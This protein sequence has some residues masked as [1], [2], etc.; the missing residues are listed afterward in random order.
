MQELTE[1]TCLSKRYTLLRRVASGG[2]ADVWLASDSR[3]DALLALKFLQGRFAGDRLRREAF[4][5]E[6]Q[7][8]SRLMHAH[9]VRVF[10]YHD[11]ED[12]PYFGQQY[13]DGPSISTLQGQALERVLGPVGLIA[14]ALRYA[15]GKGIVH[16]DITGANIVLD[17]RGAPYLLDFGVARLEGADEGRGGG[18]P[19]AQSPQQRA[20]ERAHPADDIYAFGVL[21]NELVSGAPPNDGVAADYDSHGGKLPS[22]LRDLL[23]RMLA[24]ERDARPA[25]E[26]VATALREAGFEPGLAQ[27]PNMP[28]A[29]AEMP[30]EIEVRAV[31]PRPGGQ[32]PAA[33]SS[34][35]RGIPARVVAVG[36][37][38]LLVA[39]LAVLFVLP[40]STESP[41]GESV[42]LQV[43]EPDA[44]ADKVI[45]GDAAVE[46]SVEDSEDVT[47]SE[48]LSPTDGSTTAAIKAATDEAL[49]DLLSQL[50]RLRFR[51]IERWGGQSYL[52]ALDRYAAGDQAYIARNYQAAGDHYRAT[53]TML[54]PFFD[55]IPL[56]F[57]ETM[58]AARDA[59]AAQDHREAIRL[60]DLAVAI[61]PGNADAESGL[62]RARNLDKVLQLMDRG[63]QF[64]T[65]LEYD[66]AQQAFS[67]VLQLDPAWQ[68]AEDAL[69]RISSVLEQLAF[70]SRMTE[71]FNALATDNFDS[72]RVAFEAAKAMRPGSPQPV[73]GLQQVD[74]EVRLQRIQTLEATAARQE[75][76]EQWEAAVDSY[77]EVLSV[78]GDLQFAKEGLRR[79]TSRAALHK[80]LDEYIDDPD[81]L[82]SPGTMQAATT[83]LL[84]L[85]RVDPSGPRL[86]DQK[87]VLA[88][89]L[90]RAATPLPVE[91]LSDNQTE[92]SIFRVGRLG[93]FDSRQLELRPGSYVALGSRAGYRDVR[94]E[95]RVAPEI[96]MRP[97]VVKCEEKI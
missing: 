16:S 65:N 67:N 32:A 73:D 51:G 42:P 77:D 44:D 7:I 39:F 82:S 48:N 17:E 90:K 30:E 52:D 20:G 86:E 83:L 54:E 5:R 59:F 74:Q 35:S 94:L 27:P 50:E 6:W 63:R 68:P 58:Q 80:R 75:R 14:D 23:N 21:I 4:H 3:N 10:E 43:N 56:V 9:I 89:L 40:P 76:D 91:L 37:I 46:G 15:H 47:F 84:E 96:E 8:A 12:G 19:V 34:E 45:D 72:A 97:I 85:S 62:K 29:P 87:A 78:D 24:A 28:Q 92:V 66:A 26:A 11:D 93:T 57:K 70:E 95:F 2:M 36:L 25:A 33:V 22:S 69:A 41:P 55:K 61:T 18:T 79:A 49:G 64:E 53:S 13:L 38:V 71:G 1:G 31:H 88:R 81:S 60:Y